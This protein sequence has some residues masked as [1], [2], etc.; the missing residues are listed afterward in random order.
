MAREP[1]LRSKC[2]HGVSQKKK[3]KMWAFDVLT[4]GGPSHSL[5]FLLGQN[6]EKNPTETLNATQA[7]ENPFSLKAHLQPTDFLTVFLKWKFALL[8]L[9]I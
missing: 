6:F 4:E 7:T 8:L 5:H 2:F 9:A 3:T 1:S